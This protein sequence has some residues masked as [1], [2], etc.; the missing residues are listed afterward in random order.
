MNSNIIFLAAENHRLAIIRNV[1]VTISLLLTYWRN[2]EDILH[3][4]A[5]RLT[6]GNLQKLHQN[7]TLQVYSVI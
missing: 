7:N 2:L 4:L 6:K 1:T 3:P 5:R